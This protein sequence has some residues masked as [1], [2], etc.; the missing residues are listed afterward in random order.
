MRGRGACCE[1]RRAE[2]RKA[3]HAA[4]R[5][6][7]QLEEAWGEHTTDEDEPEV[8][9][10]G[11]ERAQILEVRTS[12]EHIIY[13]PLST[14]WPTRGLPASARLHSA[15]PPSRDPLSNLAWTTQWNLTPSKC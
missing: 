9:R 1:R 10:Y 11:R 7:E 8:A 4:A 13:Q 12:P 15:C 14:S 5:R 6:A 2:R 3:R